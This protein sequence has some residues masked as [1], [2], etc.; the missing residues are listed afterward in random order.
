MKN[1]RT[2]I[3]TGISL[4]LISLYQSI[5]LKQA[6]YYSLFSIGMLIILLPI[7]SIISKKDLFKKKDFKKIII[8]STLLTISSI[9]IDK[10]GMYLNYWIYPSYTTILDEILKYSFEWAVPFAYIMLAFLIGIE[11]YQKLGL[12]KKQS[13][14]L[15]LLTFVI[16]IGFITD[17]SNLP[18]YSW[19]IINMPLTNYQIG[20]YFIM[21]ST[22]G[23]WIMTLITLILYKLTNKLQ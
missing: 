23:Y 10:I 1:K 22:V 12:N 18:V 17:T 3:I 8:F 19:K 14:I 9:I 20:P 6:H 21:F 4:I 13:F 7:Y 5:I 2:L 15:S 11:I 16:L